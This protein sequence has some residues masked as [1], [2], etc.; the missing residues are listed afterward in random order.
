VGRLSILIVE[1]NIERSLEIASLLRELGVRD[2]VRVHKLAVALEW[3]EGRALD[4][5]ICTEQLDDGDG[6]ALVAAAR[7]VSP[8]TCSLVLPED[9]WQRPSGGDGFRSLELSAWGEMLQEF[10]NGVV[11]A[12]GGFWCELPDLSLCDVLQVY[13]QLRRSISVLLSGPIAGRIR[14]E[15]GEL[16]DAATENLVGMPALSRLLEAQSGLLRTD[17]SVFEGTPTLSAPFHRVLLDALEQIDERRRAARSEGP[18]IEA[19]RSV[20]PPPAT[21]LRALAE[22]PPMVQVQ[23]S[24]QLQAPA[25]P[26]PVVQ[27]HPADLVPLIQLQPALAAPELPLP[28]LDT[29]FIATAQRKFPRPSPVFIAAS[30]LAGMVLLCAFGIYLARRSESSMPAAT[31]APSLHLTAP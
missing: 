18:F 7:H 16:V 27:V 26:L 30:V 9:K 19:K 5:L 4:V 29:A 22:P 28:Q 12:R 25:E 23:P 11:A 31:Q 24:L 2:V 10:L 14:L 1:T 13:H 6:P 3:L 8:A 20:H 17:L 15:V 21:P